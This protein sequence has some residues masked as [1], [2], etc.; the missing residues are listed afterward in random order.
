M[1]R[2]DL[3]PHLM[4]PMDQVD[5]EAERD[6]LGMPTQGL[7][8]GQPTHVPKLRPSRM[9]GESTDPHT[10][11]FALPDAHLPHPGHFDLFELD[12]VEVIPRPV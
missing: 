12:G 5:P 1:R 7:H 8:P 9:F 2:Q 4:D 10:N 6:I 3:P 11:G